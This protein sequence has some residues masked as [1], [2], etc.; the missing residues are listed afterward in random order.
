MQDVHGFGVRFT[1][2]SEHPTLRDQLIVDSRGECSLYWYGGYFSDFLG[3]RYDPVEGARSIR[4]FV[5]D[6][7]EERIGVGLSIKDGS[8]LCG[9][10][11][12]IG[13][14]E[15]LV[16]QPN[17]RSEIRTWLGTYDRIFD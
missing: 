14:P 5:E 2:P 16:F 13:S 9:G 10:P 3:W 17:A 6:V 12:E 1:V 4:L 8:V 7:L 11:V 15:G